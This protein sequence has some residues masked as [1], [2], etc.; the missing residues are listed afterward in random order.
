MATPKKDPLADLKKKTRVKHPEQA[1]I[2]D[3]QE[4]KRKGLALSKAKKKV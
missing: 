2:Q 1:R 3:L 4:R